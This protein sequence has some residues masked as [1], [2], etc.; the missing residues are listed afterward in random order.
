MAFCGPSVK[1]THAPAAFIGPLPSA[2][3]APVQNPEGSV[4]LRGGPGDGAR[5]EPTPQRRGG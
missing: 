2:E 3:P 5:E 1:G 4:G